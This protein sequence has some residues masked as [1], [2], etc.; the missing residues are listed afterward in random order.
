MRTKYRRLLWITS[1]VI[2]LLSAQTAFGLGSAD[3]SACTG[4]NI[5]FYNSHTGAAVSGKI[6]TSGLTTFAAY[7]A[8]SFST[9]WSQVSHVDTGDTILFYNGNTGSAAEGTLN[10]GVYINAENLSG[11]TLGWTDIQ[12]VGLQDNSVPLPLFYN[13]SLGSG[14]VGFSPSERIFPSGSFATGWSHIVWDGASNILFYNSGNGAAA[15]AV[16][17]LAPGTLTDVNN[18]TTTKVFPAGSF[19]HWSHLTMIGNEIFFYNNLNGSAAIGKMTPS[20][21]ANNF[22]TDQGYPANY[23]GPQWTHVLGMGSNLSVFYNSAN[24]GGAVVQMVPRGTKFPLS[25]G[26]QFQTVAL[27]PSSQVPAGFTNVVCSQDVQ[28]NIN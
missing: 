5:L 27:I 18:L 3:S 13:A 22:V 20:S 17:T 4:D 2:C 24:G 26:V 7:P 11:F 21:G 25:Q 12:Y 6:S 1:S 14:A 9:G 16:N 19:S 15:V 8:G 10:N 23:F 28:N